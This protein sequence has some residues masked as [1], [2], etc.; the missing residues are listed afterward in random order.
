MVSMIWAGVEEFVAGLG[1][2]GGSAEAPVFGGFG[3]RV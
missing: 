2:F 3:F 1:R